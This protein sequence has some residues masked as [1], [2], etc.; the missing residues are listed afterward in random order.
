[1]ADGI[2]ISVQELRVE[3]YASTQIIININQC[4]KRRGREARRKP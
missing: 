2:E 3:L 4:F 1:M